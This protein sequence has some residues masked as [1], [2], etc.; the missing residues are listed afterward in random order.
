MRAIPPVVNRLRCSKYGRVTRYS[1]SFEI[2]GA[3]GNALCNSGG[4]DNATRDDDDDHDDGEKEAA[5]TVA[6]R[7]RL[8]LSRRLVF[9]NPRR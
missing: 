1:L 6:S 5:H 3:R 7:L 8:V 2:R 9:I 4:T